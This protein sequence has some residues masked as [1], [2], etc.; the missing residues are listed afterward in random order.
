MGVKGKDA[1]IEI[2]RRLEQQAA[3]FRQ[4]AQTT[5]QS[6]SRQ[7]VVARAARRDLGPANRLSPVGWK[8]SADVL[9]F[10]LTVVNPWIESAVS[11]NPPAN[12]AFRKQVSGRAVAMATINIP[13]GQK[14][15]VVSNPRTP[16]LAWYC[17][18]ATGVA[19]S[20]QPLYN[21][22]NDPEAQAVGTHAGL[23]FGT[24]AAYYSGNPTKIYTLNDAGNV[25]VW[26]PLPLVQSPFD[27]L[28]TPA[29]YVATNTA[30]SP[31]DHMFEA[32]LENDALWNTY[33]SSSNQFLGG[34][35]ECQLAVPFNGGCVL[36]W[37]DPQSNERD[38]TE[39]APQGSTNGGDLLDSVVLRRPPLFSA[40]AS[41][42]VYYDNQTTDSSWLGSKP[43]CPDLPT[44]IEN[45]YN[46]KLIVGAT[47]D[48]QMTIRQQLIPD[49]AR[50]WR[51]GSWATNTIPAVVNVAANN[52][53]GTTAVYDAEMDDWVVLMGGGTNYNQP[54]TCEPP[55]CHLCRFPRSCGATDRPQYVADTGLGWVPPETASQN[56]AF[57]YAETNKRLGQLFG[58]REMFESMCS[59]LVVDNTASSVGMSVRVRCIATFASVVT[60]TQAVYGA[61]SP[62]QGYTS[63]GHSGYGF[64][65]MGPNPRAAS[66]S[67]ARAACAKQARQTNNEMYA[68]LLPAVRK[69]IATGNDHSTTAGNI[70]T[71]TYKEELAQ[72]S[73]PEQQLGFDFFGSF[74]KKH[75]GE[76]AKFLAKTAIDHGTKYVAK[77]MG[78]WFT[79][80]AT[81]PVEDLLM[82]E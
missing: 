10:F 32:L 18:S 39:D 23:G 76:G 72:I 29:Q 20:T 80:L 48:A 31:L 73:N 54:L 30:P 67:A 65:G 55:L 14:L 24:T 57:A 8:L 27:Y 81:D 50:T 17:L 34:E 58:V 49:G 64:T 9:R 56:N 44:H 75:L 46:T 59:A 51:A 82:I 41:P 3:S 42:P 11:M 16:G 37:L 70:P 66:W 35:L 78:N 15:T 33:Q 38:F 26:T 25:N 1:K 21:A 4:A 40:Y 74:F 71:E 63:R 13:A 12:A 36:G 53:A 61:S 47:P 52:P 77:R 79:D 68:A 19:V 60:P 45:F 62:I 22:I 2:E 6:A 28:T 43:Y 69:V 7:L 5:V